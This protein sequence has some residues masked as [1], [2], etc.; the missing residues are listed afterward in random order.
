MSLKFLISGFLMVLVFKA[1]IDKTLC[2]ALGMWL[3]KGIY[4]TLRKGIL[5]D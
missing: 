5:F 3:A 4:V 2:S 1:Q